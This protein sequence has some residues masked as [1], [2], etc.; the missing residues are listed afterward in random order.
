MAGL[1]SSH[2][3]TPSH[4]YAVI[5]TATACNGEE[6]V[7]V[8]YYTT[9]YEPNEDIHEIAMASEIMTLATGLGVAGS[10]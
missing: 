7:Q 3:S 2:F 5:L 10:S 4:A 9:I 6:I 1:C 8:Y